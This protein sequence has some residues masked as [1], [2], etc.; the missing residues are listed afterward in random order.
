MHSVLTKPIDWLSI[1]LARLSVHHHPGDHHPISAIEKFVGDPEFFCDFVQVP[2]DLSLSAERDFR[3]T[4]PIVTPAE[5]NNVVMG[6]WF[7]CQ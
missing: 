3:Y 7:P 6:K 2:E 1:Q 5:E 4:S